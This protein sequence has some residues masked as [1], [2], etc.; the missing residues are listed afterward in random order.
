MYSETV[1]ASK[2]H[3][4]AQGAKCGECVSY[5]DRLRAIY[6]RWT[7]HELIPP[8]SNARSH[9]NERW[10]TAALEIIKI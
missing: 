4:L 3:H 9:T 10:L 6:H 1:R 8:C 2:Y 5:R 7:K